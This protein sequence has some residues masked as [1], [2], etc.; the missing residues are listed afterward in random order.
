MRD[1]KF[2]YTCVRENGYIFSR[3]F[4]IEQIESG[5][6]CQWWEMNHIGKSQIHKDQYIGRKDKNGK[7]IYEGDIVNLI[8]DGY[9]KERAYVCWDD[10]NTGYIY[11]RISSLEIANGEAIYTKW[12]PVEVIG[13][14]Y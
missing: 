6:V 12:K 5:E 14:I 2:K 3:I 7:E 11:R 9:A 1:I 13:N 10:K 8:L 4:T